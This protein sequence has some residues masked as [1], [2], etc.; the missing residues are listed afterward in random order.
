M[1]L[2]EK[3]DSSTGVLA[4]T[5]EWMQEYNSALARRKYQRPIAPGPTF[6]SVSVGGR[7]GRGGVGFHVSMR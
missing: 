1:Q 5:P 2:D 7:E 3:L 4:E 6:C